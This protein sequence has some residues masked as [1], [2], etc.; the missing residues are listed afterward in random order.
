[1]GKLTVGDEFFEAW[2]DTDEGGLGVDL[3]VI[4]AIREGRV[5]ACKKT[6][7]TWVKLSPKTGDYGWARSLSAYD[8]RAFA[9]DDGPPAAWA[10]T[11]SAAYTKALPA[12]EAAIKRLT[13]LRA[14]ITGQRTKARN[15]ARPTSRAA[16]KVEA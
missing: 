6:D 8:R 12:V 3:W 7:Y 10:K 9:Q 15:R 16:L 4:T 2:V 11:K 13:K 14:Q 1:M 5:F